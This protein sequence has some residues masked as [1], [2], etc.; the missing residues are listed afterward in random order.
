MTYIIKRSYGNSSRRFNNKTFETYEKARQYVRRW[1]GK[2]VG[3]ENYNN[4][5]G[6]FAGNDNVS[7][8]YPSISVLGFSIAKR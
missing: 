1:I 5:D 7:R 4:R 2:N 3:I 6:D 8:N